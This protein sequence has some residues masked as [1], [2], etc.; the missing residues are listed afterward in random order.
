V[1]ARAAEAKPIL[2]GKSAE[3]PLTAEEL[4][5]IRQHLRFLREHRRVLHLRVNAHEDLLLNEVREP[6][7]RGVCQHLLSKVD[8]TQVFSAAKRLEP[9]AASRLAEGVLRIS[10]NLDYLLLYL[11]CVR[12]S[13][14]Q[15]H[16]VSAL[17][18]ALQ[19]MDFAALSQ[20]QMRRVLD[21]IV[22]L[23][24]E[25]QLPQMLLGLLEGKAF[26]EAFDASTAELPEA[27]AAIVVPLRAAQAVVLH[28]K[29]NRFGPEMLARGVRLL[30]QGDPGALQRYPLRV[31]RRLLELGSSSGAAPETL[32]ALLETLNTPGQ[33]AALDHGRLA[34]QLAREW[35]GTNRERD[36]RQLLKALERTRPELRQPQRWLETLDQP[37]LGRVA[38]TGPPA[39]FGQS[40]NRVPAVFL[41]T[42][43][44]ATLFLAAEGASDSDALVEVLSSLAVPGLAPLLESGVDERGNAYFAVARQGQTLSRLLERHNATDRRTLLGACREAA[45]LLAT[46]AR[47]GIRLPDAE[48]R[49]FELDDS[50]RLWLS[51]LLG[52]VPSSVEECESAHAQL[53]ARFCRDILAT[54]GAGLPPAGL[55]EQL[56]EATTATRAASVLA[57]CSA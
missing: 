28:D 48:L 1:V 25:R 54:R 21:L 2:E 38:L 6:T 46:L 20:G 22:E 37:R 40:L 35:I 18:H 45:A 47:L 56:D 5:E 39:R 15:Q 11:D 17:A 29:V 13:A 41:T 50:R 8:R 33:E 43:Q 9:A 30:L 32:L 23:F 57:R 52:A 31:R 44:A 10:P 53:I 7:R 42:M 24:D 12:R 27:L 14:S 49:R 36:A 26:R 4:T 51:D 55:L 34:L 19:R 16:A 3:E